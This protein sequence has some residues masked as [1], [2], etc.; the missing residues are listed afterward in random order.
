MPTLLRLDSSPL[1]T[2]VSRALTD[3]YVHAWKTV[4]PDG[5]VIV[6]DLTLTPPPPIDASWI[7]AS[8]TPPQQR[9]GEQQRLLALS[10]E[11]IDELERAEEY[12]IG[13]AMHNFSIPSVLKLWV[14]QVV[15]VGRTF[16]YSDSG[17]LGL[18]QGKSAS[19]LAATGG[20]YSAGTPTEGMNFLDPYL[21][22]VLGFL[23]VRDVK[24]VTAGGTSQLRSPDVDR[25]AFLRPVLEQV[26]RTAA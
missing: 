26:R 10:D 5:V 24:V 2:S 13:V 12:V 8:F 11:L 17:P 9:T 4:H 20:V 6:R 16:G 7:G 14:D 18:L 3:E 23:G 22:V 15:R 25:E 19:I 1:S 21:K